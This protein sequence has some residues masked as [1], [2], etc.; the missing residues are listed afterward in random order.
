M[1]RIGK[2]P[3]EVPK[4]VTVEING[5]AVKTKGPKGELDW[6]VPA[7]IT[8]EFDSDSSQIQV[9]RSNDRKR[10][11]AMHGL[12][13]SVIANMVH[14]VDKG[15]EKKLEVYGTGY[16]C[17]VKN[18]QLLLNCGFMGRGIDA[19]GKPRE[20]QFYIDI[21]EDL[22]VTVEVKAA[23]GDT[24]PARFSITGADKQRV[25]QFAAEVRGIRPSEP[26]KGKGLRYVDEYVRRKQGKAFAGG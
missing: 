16:G 14:G 7:D 1:S 5:Q 11:R 18:N 9:D 17:D 4:G 12:A 3:I 22:T 8:V 13:R 20:A 21:P 24:E 23:R 15:Y 25:G 2:K 6:A 10:T 26:Y 19:D